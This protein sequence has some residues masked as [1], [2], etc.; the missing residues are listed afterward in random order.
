[1]AYFGLVIRHRQS[2]SEA[3]LDSTILRHSYS[4]WRLVSTD[5][6]TH[7]MV[8]MVLRSNEENMPLIDIKVTSI[9]RRS[10]PVHSN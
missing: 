4:D 10:L 7:Y 2:L 8:L 9:S 5:I 1:M 3:R 6:I